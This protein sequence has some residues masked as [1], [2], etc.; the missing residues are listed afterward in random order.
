MGRCLVT[1]LQG[2]TC[3]KNARQS[4]PREPGNLAQRANTTKQKAWNS[5][6]NHKDSCAEGMR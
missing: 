3:S 2:R 6:N 4:D 1:D 5:R